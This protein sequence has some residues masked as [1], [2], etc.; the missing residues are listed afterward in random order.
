MQEIFDVDPRHKF[1]W[2]GGAATATDLSD[3]FEHGAIK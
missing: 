2:L 3:L 1:T